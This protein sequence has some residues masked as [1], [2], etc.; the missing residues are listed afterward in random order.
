MLRFVVRR[1]LLLIPILFGVS[2]LVFFWVHELPGGPVDRRC[3]ASGRRR[4]SCSSTRRRTGSNDPLPVQYVKY[5]KTLANGDLGVSVRLPAT[6]HD[7]I[8]ERFPATIE[9]A[10]AAMVFAVSIGLPLGFL[11]RRSTT[12][13]RAITRP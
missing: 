7:E 3:S 5:M 4:S 12:A 11:S 13:V 8:R 9:L 2:V 1:L 6:D 10:I